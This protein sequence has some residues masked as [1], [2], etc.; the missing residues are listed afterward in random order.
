MKKHQIKKMQELEKNL[1]IA[2][3]LNDVKEKISNYH[4]KKKDRNM[5]LNSFNCDSQLIN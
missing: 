4:Q 3:H 5:K 1:L 2:N